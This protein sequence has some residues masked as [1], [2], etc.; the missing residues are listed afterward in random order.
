[1]ARTASISTRPT[2]IVR[3]KRATRE[4]VKTGA[5]AERMA[6]VLESAVK[7]G[8]FLDKDGRIAGRVSTK[9]IRNAKERTGIENNTALIEFALASVALEDG[10]SESF[11]AA[12]G[13]V[14]SELKL[15]F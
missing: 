6:A 15:G 7:L 1:M 8:L 13:Q 12:R 10:F 2:K 3:R 5:K 11:K 14:D 4:K 9:L